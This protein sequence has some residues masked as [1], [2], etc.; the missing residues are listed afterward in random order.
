VDYKIRI[1]F[2]FLLKD[3]PEFNRPSTDVIRKALD[4]FFLELEKHPK[5]IPYNVDEVVRLEG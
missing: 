2:W 5:G 3:Q 1:S 4:D